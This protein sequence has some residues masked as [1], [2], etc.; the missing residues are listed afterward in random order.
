GDPA[1]NG[2]AA[3]EL[4][5]RP[6]ASEGSDGEAEPDPSIE[7]APADETGPTDR[8]EAD[9]Q[10]AAAAAEPVDTEP[11]DDPRPTDVPPADT[12][13]VDTE[14]DDDPRATDARPAD[15]EPV[16]ATPGGDPRATDVPPT[17]TEPVAAEPDGDPRPSDA[18]APVTDLGP[19]IGDDP[20]TAG[21]PPTA[22][23]VP[24]L[25]VP[26]PPPPGSGDPSPD[27]STQ[28]AGRPVAEPMLFRL[29]DDRPAGIPTG[30]DR[31]GAQPTRSAATP[32]AA[33][34]QPAPVP[35]IILDQPAADRAGRDPQP[36]R[37]HQ[38]AQVQTAPAQISARSAPA[39]SGRR[40]PAF[41]VAILIGGLFGVGAAVVLTQ[42]VD[43]GSEQ[44]APATQVAAP[45]DDGQPAPAA[46]TIAD[47]APPPSLVD[48]GQ[49][50]LHG[51]AFVPGTA[52]LTAA[53][54]D[55]LAEVVDAVAQYPPEATTIAVR[56][57][58]EP[59]AQAN[60]DLSARQAQAVAD[61]LTALGMEFGGLSL[62]G[63]GAAP[64]V[65]ALPVQNF[66]VVGTGLRA[67]ALAPM[68]D[69]LSPFA[70]GIDPGT[71]TL[72]PESREVLDRVG[73]LMAAAPG[74]T[75]TLAGYAY[76]QFGGPA[77]QRLAVASTDAAQAYLVDAH[78]IEPGRVAVVAPGSLPFVVGTD[79]GTHVELRW[80]RTA[81]V[82]VAVADLDR[83][84][85]RFTAGSAVLTDAASAQFERLAALLSET[86]AD[87]V[88][89]IRTATEASVAANAELSSRQAAAVADY[90]SGTGLDGG[91]VRVFGGGDVARL[92]SDGPA[93]EVTVTILP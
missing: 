77:N 80:G 25:P 12:E 32:P 89:H 62:D 9:D 39:R 63:R 79:I 57:F 6:Q 85:L 20:S 64:L 44:A 68:I 23:E 36:A 41:A 50:S 87:A 54:R 82:A 76:D 7:P 70:I 58:S 29:T 28:P 8:A 55:R 21:D 59:T 71:G 24:A 72:R 78:G 86:G 37:F 47:T 69:D 49:L 42:A 67:S 93:S 19:A 16:D 2:T 15:T 52:E 91:Q 48:N 22:D 27:R 88:I 53:S 75:I 40:W 65:D 35:A 13:P 74:G 5:D 83:A 60:R 66:V 34:S 90:L 31:V 38:S 30:R 14:P 84:A 10:T 18:A 1:T 17:D 26:P 4:A 45:T 61:Q 3:G 11:D 46:P 92:R 56:T 73:Q 81:A 51:I 33:D 43:R